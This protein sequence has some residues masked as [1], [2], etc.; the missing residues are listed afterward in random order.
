MSVAAPR[1]AAADRRK[2]LIETAIR[3]QSWLARSTHWRTAQRPTSHR[4]GH[5]LAPSSHAVISHVRCNAPRCIE[6]MTRSPPM[7]STLVA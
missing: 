7:V 3:S 1:M 6:S 4:C 2:H 5:S